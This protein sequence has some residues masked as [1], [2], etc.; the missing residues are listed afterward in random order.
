MNS[1]PK[2][3]SASLYNLDC[4]YLEDVRFFR[5]DLETITIIFPEK[6]PENFPGRFFFMPEGRTYD[7][8]AFI[9]TLSEQ[10]HINQ[11]ASE[12]APF[13]I[14]RA[15]TNDIPEQRKNY[16]VYVTFQAAI[17]PEG[18]K[19]ESFVTIKDIGTGGFQF[20]SKQKFEADT[21]FTTIFTSIKAPECITARIQK[22]RPVREKGVYSYG[23]QFVNLPPK[24]EMLIRN[25]VF[26]TETLQAKA[27]REKENA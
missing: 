18:Q 2:S 15:V 11:P 19:K 12:A 7:Y 25:F 27:K 1:I 23:C 6:P 4:T 5:E 20:V 26:Q 3:G 22:Q 17:L 13:Y 16:R 14:A 8:R 24:L 10:I 21:A 9:F